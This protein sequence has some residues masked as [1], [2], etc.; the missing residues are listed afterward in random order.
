MV[1][2]T[3]M[4]HFAQNIALRTIDARERIIQ[5]TANIE[6]LSGTVLEVVVLGTRHPELKMDPPTCSKQGRFESG[7][8]IWN[9]SARLKSERR[10]KLMWTLNVLHIRA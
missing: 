9:S 10:G 6:T 4:A 8:K 7:N 3:N 1:F 5:P 2:V